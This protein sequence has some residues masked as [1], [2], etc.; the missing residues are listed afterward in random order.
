MRFLSY[1]VVQMLSSVATRIPPQ[2]NLKMSGKDCSSP[3]E[4]NFEGPVGMIRIDAKGFFRLNYNEKMKNIYQQPASYKFEGQT[5]IPNYFCQ[6]CTNVSASRR[7]G[8]MVCR[9]CAS[10]FCL[11]ESEFS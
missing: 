4:L 9:S 7:Y 6:V 3:P 11:F 5:G 1:A 2:K 10:F 8:K